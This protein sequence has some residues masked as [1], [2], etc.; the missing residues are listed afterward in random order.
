MVGEG[1]HSSDDEFLV[2]LAFAF[3]HTVN[4]TDRD[5]HRHRKLGQVAVVTLAELKNPRPYYQ[6]IPR[7]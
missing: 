4:L 3:T 6:V 7:I 5:S 2:N 1:F